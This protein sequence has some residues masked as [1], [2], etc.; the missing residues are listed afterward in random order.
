MPDLI[1]YWTRK[2]KNIYQVVSL[3]N[4]KKRMKELDKDLA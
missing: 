3:I 1:N 2:K 4:K